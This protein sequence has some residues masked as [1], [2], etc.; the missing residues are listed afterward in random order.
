[1]IRCSR[2]ITEMT[3]M[4]ASSAETA[5]ATQM[6]SYTKNGAAIRTAVLSSSSGYRAEM[7]SPQLWHRPRSKTHPRTGMLSRFRISAPHRGHRE[8]GATTDSPAGTRAATTVMKLPIARPNRAATGA[9]QTVG[10]S[11]T[12]DVELLPQD[13]LVRGAES[14]DA[15]DTRVV[16]HVEP[17]LEV[18]RLGVQGPVADVGDVVRGVDERHLPRGVQRP[19]HAVVRVGLHT[20]IELDRVLSVDAAVR[21]AGVDER[22]GTG[23]GRLI[24]RDHGQVGRDRGRGRRHGARVPERDGRVRDE[25]EVAAQGDAVEVDRGR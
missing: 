4:S 18:H 16:D 19:H 6:L 14:K 7:R 1:M 5:Q 10:T 3:G 8:R 21:A 15:L 2:S 24:R 9:S 11:R 20:G 12:L 25:G 22:G 23:P 17:V 13:L